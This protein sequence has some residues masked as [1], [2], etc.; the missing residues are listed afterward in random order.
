MRI[1][2]IK[3]KDDHAKDIYLTIGVLDTFLFDAVVSSISQC[4]ASDARLNLKVAR[5]ILDEG[6]RAVA[7]HSREGFS[8][9]QIV[10]DGKNRC[11]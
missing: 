6:H 4:N 3:I 7:G 10:E 11:R 9:P 8:P 5:A 1:N 2:P